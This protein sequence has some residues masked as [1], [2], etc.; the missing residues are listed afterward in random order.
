L[1]GPQERA[2]SLHVLDLLPQLLAEDLGVE[3]GAGHGGVAALGAQRVELA[4][5][6]LGQEVEALPRRPGLGEQGAEVL[7]VG[8]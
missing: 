5:D 2:G 4:E 7:D 8:P 1:G 6:L 3:H